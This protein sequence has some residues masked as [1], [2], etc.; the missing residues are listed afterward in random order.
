MLPKPDR[1]S[2]KSSAEQLDLVETINEVDKTKNKRL[3]III[4]LLLTV[5]LSLSFIF[6]RQF[7]NIDL[8]NFKIPEI[9]FKLQPL[10]LSKF[11]P[12]VPESWSILVQ[13]IGTTSYS[14]S[15]N[16]IPQ[17]FTKIKTLHNPAYAKKYLPDG[18]VITEKVSSNSDFL[19]IH[20][21][22]STPKINF[23]IYT[24]IP[25]KI[26]SSSPEIDTFS[27]LVSVF[28]WHLLKNTN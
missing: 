24:K 19:E 13:S 20:S 7:K 16:Y 2:K 4:F 10:S 17:D 5:G 15:S 3:S 27:Q 1:S 25:G 14:F 8:K 22:I 18:V 6:Y 21:Q 12:T 11:S 9:S 26:D 23:E 28:Y